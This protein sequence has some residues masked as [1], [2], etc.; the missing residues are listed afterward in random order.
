MELTPEAAANM[1]GCRVDNARDKRVANSC[2]L[3]QFE[4]S[5]RGIQR[6]FAADRDRFIT[7]RT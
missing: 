3:E 1:R 4:L 6:D 2:S 5:E 7:S